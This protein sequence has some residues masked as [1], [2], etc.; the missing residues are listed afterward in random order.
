MD[1]LQSGPAVQH[2][3]TRKVETPQMRKI[4]LKILSERKCHTTTLFMIFE[5]HPNLSPQIQLQWGLMCG[6]AFRIR[7]ATS[8]QMLGLMLGVMISGQLSDAFGR[9]W[10]RFT[11]AALKSDYFSSQL[12][13]FR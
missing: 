6:K 13:I 5:T 7:A 10:A 4:G 8:I 9:K 3:T 11:A 2:N 1:P 12:A